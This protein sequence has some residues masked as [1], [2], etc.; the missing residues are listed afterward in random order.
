MRKD[1]H[2][3]TEQALGRVGRFGI[4]KKESEMG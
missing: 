2:D 4:K 1:M 3:P